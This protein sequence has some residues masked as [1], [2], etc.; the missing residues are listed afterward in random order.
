MKLCTRCRRV[1]DFLFAT[2]L[3]GGSIAFAQTNALWNE[4]STGPGFWIY[5]LQ[6]KC[7]EIRAR[8]KPIVFGLKARPVQPQYEVSELR[9]C[10]VMGA[11]PTQSVSCADGHIHLRFI[12]NQNRFS[13][14]Y[15]FRMKD[16]SRKAGEFEADFC[17][18]AK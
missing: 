2:F 14:S 15:S 11:D 9:Y 4:S 6:G 17:E 12:E 1:R 18:A 3:C 5:P 16:G 7:P 10:F 8:A 13:G